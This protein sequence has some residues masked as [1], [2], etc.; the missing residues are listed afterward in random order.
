MSLA[1][2]LQNIAR[3]FLKARTI[4]PTRP[5]PWAPQTGGVAQKAAGLQGAFHDKVRIPRPPTSA[6][7]SDRMFRLSKLLRD[8]DSLI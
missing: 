6:T 4:V 2:A 7:C 8:A 3:A 5:H 1:F